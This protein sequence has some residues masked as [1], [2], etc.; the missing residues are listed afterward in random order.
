MNLDV[1]EGCRIQDSEYG[2]LP[3]LSSPSIRVLSPMMPYKNT[4]GLTV[5]HLTAFC[6]N[7]ITPLGGCPSPPN[8]TLLKMK[9]FPIK[10][11]SGC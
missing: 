9:V 5:I 8:P 7:G 11:P 4:S 10:F 1:I 6:I 2:N 3:T